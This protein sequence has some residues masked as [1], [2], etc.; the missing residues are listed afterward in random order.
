MTRVVPVAGQAPPAPELHRVKQGRVISGV[1]TGLAAHLGAPVTRI[2]SV[3]AL[4]CI[5]MGVGAVTYVA[6]RVFTD[7]VGTAAEATNPVSARR[8]GGEA[9]TVGTTDRLLVPLALMICIIGVSASPTLSVT[10]ILVIGGSVL[11][12]R[13][14]GPDVSTVPTRIGPRSPGTTQW[15]SLLGGLLLITCGL[16][17]WAYRT[18]WDV[19]STSFLPALIAAVALV[20]GI[21]VVLIPLWLKLWSTADAAARERA[22]AEERARIAAR[23]HDSVLQTLTVIQRQSDQPEIARLARTQERQLRQWLFG[24]GESVSTQTLFGGIRVACGEVEDMFGVQIRP[25]TVGEDRTVDSSLMSLVLAG[26]EAMVNA[27]K[28]SGCREINV[29]CESSEEAVDLFVRDRGPGFRVAEIPADRQGVRRSIIDRMTRCGGTATID[30]GSFGT[31]VTLHLGSMHLGGT[32]T[33]EQ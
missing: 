14:F 18:W 22:A 7:Q 16:A 12:W 23:I 4:S 25:V 32:G 11:V 30:S 28:H 5:L 1:C 29:Y 19:D 26:R 33:E 6:L 3:F 20:I 31:E 9:T 21:L 24:T 17:F 15:A 2:R 13:T 27:A 10:V 8:S